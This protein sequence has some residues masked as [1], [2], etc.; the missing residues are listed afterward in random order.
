M[1]DVLGRPDGLGALRVVSLAHVH[2]PA[3]TPLFPGD[4]EFT[5]TTAATIERDG[6]YLQRVSRGEHTGTHWGAP[7]HFEPGGALADELCPADL[8]LPAVRIDVRAAV[9]ADQDYQVSTADLVA[10]ER[11]HGRIPAGAAV[12]AWTGWSDRWGTAAYPNLDGQGRMHQPGFSPDAA[13]WLIGTGR[14][15]RRGALGSDTFGPDPG[16]DAS[17][18]VSRELFHEH[19]ISLENLTNLQ[20]LPAA[21]AWV[22]AGGAVNRAGSGSAATVFGLIPRQPC[23]GGRRIRTVRHQDGRR[24]R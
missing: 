10:F 16:L 12:I 20:D 19:R 9:A 15:G 4:P 8:F 5:L 14:L 1:R 22:L 21:G 17:F 18:A 24:H 3:L 2:D 7:G 23:A 6:Y 13:R 11:R